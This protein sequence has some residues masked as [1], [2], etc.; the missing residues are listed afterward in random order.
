LRRGSLRAAPRRA[1]AAA[2]RRK[3]TAMADP[4]QGD[5][6]SPADLEREIERLEARAAELRGR[7]AGGADGGPWWPERFYAAYHVVVGSM[8]GLIAAGAS[9]L[10]NV[11]GSLMTGREPLQL[12]KIYLTFPLGERAFQSENGVALSTGVLLYLATGMVFG[13]AMHAIGQ[14][15]FAQ[16]QLARR[17]ALA[18]L[19]GLVLWLINYYAI[20]VWLQP[21][22]FHGDWIVRQIPPPVAAATHLVFTWTLTLLAFLGR[23]E[24]PATG[25]TR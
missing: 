3:E 21:L 20:L 15:W 16:A 24:P 5:A 19:A 17:L 2:L 13:A 8:L 14:R 1:E 9:L 4:T 18:T 10:F 11:V 7:L 25:T 12:I 22:L 23:F 6:A